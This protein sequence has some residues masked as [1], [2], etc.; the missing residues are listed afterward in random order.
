MFNHEPLVKHLKLHSIVK[1]AGRTF[2]LQRCP[3]VLASLIVSLFLDSHFHAFLPGNGN[4]E[5]TDRPLQTRK[6]TLRQNPMDHFVL[7]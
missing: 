1:L 7:E 4:S 5:G 2:Q 6:Y 3:G